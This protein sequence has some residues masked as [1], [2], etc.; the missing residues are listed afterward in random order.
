MIKV[1]HVHLEFDRVLIDDG[2]MNIKNGIIT[3]LI[4]E[5]GAGKS[6][7]LQELALFGRCQS[8]QY[9]F[10]GIKIHETP[11]CQRIEILR[12]DICYIMQDIYF[13]KDM[14]I[15]EVMKFNASIINKVIEE[16]DIYDYLHTVNLD[17]DIHTLVETLS[18]GEK[19]CLLIACGLLKN[20]KLFIF[21][22]PFAYL[23]N[24]N[25]ENIFEIIQK[26]A[27]SKK[28]MVVVSSHD[29][30]IYERFDC[31]YEI[32]NNCLNNIKD[33]HVEEIELTHNY[34]TFQFDTLKKYVHFHYKKHWVKYFGFIFFISLFVMMTVLMV[35]F[36]SQFQKVN[37][38]SI[39]T[40]IKNEVY[41]VRKDHE[42][43]SPTTLSHLKNE[44]S[45]Y[46]LYP[47]CG[48]NSDNFIYVRGYLDNEKDCFSIY[49]LLG[50][51]GYF[52][53]ND[54][55]EIYIPYSLYRS[56]KTDKYTIKDPQGNLIQIQAT[57]VLNPSEG[58]TIYVPYNILKDYL[59]NIEIDIELTNVEGIK[60]PIETIE[61]IS[62]IKK[63][64]SEN[65][66]LFQSD[67]IDLSIQAAT[68]FDNNYV[69]I[70]SLFALIILCVY[71]IFDTL[72]IRKDYVLLKMNGV[73]NIALI[74]MKF[75][76][77]GLF[78]TPCIFL[79]I[80]IYSLI[81]KVLHLLTISIF[82]DIFIKIGLF[83]ASIYFFIVIVY[84]IVVI[85]IPTIKLLRM[86]IS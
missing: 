24:Q 5:S 44:L 54:I 1:S 6:A 80:T 46:Q 14:T 73:N 32:K 21:D 57:A 56:I 41:I 13:Y 38:S 2:S 55:G 42:E 10:D 11:L 43:I 9:D 29:S 79:S 17:L 65:C 52:N 66:I 26:L 64:V 67:I 81:A 22:E 63:V 50:E 74:K 4:G 34:S 47:E 83:Y 58:K 70:I 71:K 75:Y 69:N 77:E 68:L 7:L 39:L 16:D 19:Q 53:N 12:Q 60:I 18:G 51:E 33:C 31:I 62:Q 30:Y 8:M 35:S 20:A 36:Q 27:Y 59:K 48:F 85:K 40:I 82:I 72:K 61:D 76:Q 86:N 78:F 37:G 49:K 15:S 25:I 84:S 23:D 3:G 45:E 28:K